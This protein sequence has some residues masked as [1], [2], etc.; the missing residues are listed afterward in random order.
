MHQYSRRD[1]LKLLFLSPLVAHCA[2]SSAY[3]RQQDIYRD[4]YN[5][6]SRGVWTYLKGR[7]F[8]NPLEILSFFQDILPSTIWRKDRLEDMINHPDEYHMPSLELDPEGLPTTPTDIRVYLTAVAARWGT[9]AD[10][11]HITAPFAQYDWL[12]DFGVIRH[13]D[14][15]RIY[16]DPEKI[17]KM[18]EELQQRHYPFP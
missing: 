17:T 12:V 7:R 2:V 10:P 6:L 14:T 5:Q 15:T 9:E 3:R 1:I 8:R 16:H 11:L 13:G 4:I 18:G